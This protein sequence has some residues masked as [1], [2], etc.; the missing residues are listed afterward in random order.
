[1]NSVEETIIGI[2]RVDFQNKSAIALQ[3]LLNGLKVKVK[4]SANST[5]KIYAFDGETTDSNRLVE[6]F[7]GIV[8]YRFTSFYFYEFIYLF[9]NAEKI[10]VLY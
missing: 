9:D 6:I 3:A 2:D 4:F 8:V 10:T 5:E 1:M 7:D